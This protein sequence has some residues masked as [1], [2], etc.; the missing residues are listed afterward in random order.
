[1]EGL[2]RG[3]RKGYDAAYALDRMHRGEALYRD[4]PWTS[5]FF[6]RPPRRTY[7]DGRPLRGCRL[8][9]QRPVAPSGAQS[10]EVL[11]HRLTQSRTASAHGPGGCFVR[12][13]PAW[14]HR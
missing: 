3:M 13:M 5:D 1:M 6:L 2:G 14:D 4:G 11:R 10:D 8:R 12:S 9:L 7:G